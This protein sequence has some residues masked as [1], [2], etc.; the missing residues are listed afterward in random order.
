MKIM[1]KKTEYKP[2]NIKDF[3]KDEQVKIRFNESD[4]SIFTYIP[5]ES[6][7][8]FRKIIFKQCFDE[9]TGYFDWMLYDL[10]FKYLVLEYY[11]DL[12]FPKT[13]VEI[14]DGDEDKKQRVVDI[15][16]TYDSAVSGQLYDYIFA[17]IG[18]DIQHL[19]DMIMD[20]V[21]EK[22]REVQFTHSLGYMIG[23]FAEKMIQLNPED[24]RGLVDQI[25]QIS[26]LKNISIIKDI[27]EKNTSEPAKSM[28]GEKKG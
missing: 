12:K 11:T 13:T 16:A 18:D 27:V 23:G 25:G 10:F 17:Q 5:M 6:K 3:N 4:I 24:V 15:Y 1:K 2:C 14:K 7:I 26:D 22:R 9:K 28:V 20:S 21:E 19:Q 8:A